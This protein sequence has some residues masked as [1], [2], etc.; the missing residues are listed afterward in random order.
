[1]K[2]IFFILCFGLS[3]NTVAQNNIDLDPVTVTA[4]R[5]AQKAKETGS[6]ISIIDGKAFQQL[7]VHSLDDLLRYIPGVEIQQRG[8]AGSQADVVLRGG[9]FQ[10]VLVLLDGI[11]IN[12]P[13]TGH[14]SSY[15][16]IAPYEIERIEILRGPAAAIYGSEAVGG[17]IHIISK[18]FN[19]FKKHNSTGGTVAAS[20]GEYGFWNTELGIHHTSKKVNIA[21]GLLSNNA[22]G[23]LLRGNNR[24]FF[25]NNTASLSA[26]VELVKNWQLN[27]RSAMDN[28]DF[29]AQNFYTSF[30]SDTATE[31]VKSWWNQAQLKHGDS[32]RSDEISVA[33][34]QTT[35]HY[36]YNSRSIPNDNKSH[37]LFFQYAH[38]GRLNKNTS[39]TYGAM[40]DDRL[41]RSNDRGDHATLRGAAF[42][43]FRFS[44]HSLHINPSLRID[45]DENYG[46][47]LLP[48]LNIAYA[49]KKINFRANVGRAVRAA[50]FT[51]RY[52]NYGKALVTSGSIGNPA[53]KAERSWSYEAGADLLLKQ[54]KLSATYFIRDQQNLI[55]YVT[56]AYADMPRK[57]NLIPTGT[58]AL[59]KN[60]RRV[61]TNGFEANLAWQHFFAAK[62]S[63]LVNAG[64]SLLHSS[65]TEPNPSFYIISH[66][67]TLLQGNLAY[68]FRGLSLSLTA[69]YKERAAQKAAGINAV[70]SKDYFLVN[71]KIEYRFLNSLSMFI[72]CNNIGNVNYSDLLG[73]RMPG[74]WTS[75]GLRLNF[76]FPKTTLVI[77]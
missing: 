54:F 68:Q 24:G 41:I 1:M 37:F 33:W 34:K 5:G 71:G 11:K 20:A 16:P 64:I 19:S 27:L 59:A 45:K 29:A 25:H 12:D 44:L 30:A 61:H 14:F 50:D 55:D 6:S 52:N 39:L 65:S 31:R 18:T 73:S 23:Q 63:L 74:S 3:L 13:V 21:G 42:A 2:Q 70:I 57:D 36:V 46:T 43:A 56:T 7:P 10:Q 32:L 75:A 53:L 9:T 28:R 58:Y 77:P 17:V 22:D 47:E 62:H 4:S 69:I 15:L 40:L 35:D 49:V 8:P 26:S 72:S 66:A 67:K 76:N 51:E 48:Q 60:I 38:N